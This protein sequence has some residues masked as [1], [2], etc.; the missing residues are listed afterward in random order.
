VELR[1]EIEQ[2]LARRADRTAGQI[3]ITINDGTVILTGTVHSWLQRRAVVGAVGHAP[4]VQAVDDRL[5]IDPH[6]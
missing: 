6:H 5:Q 4:G 2:A 1:G 3:G